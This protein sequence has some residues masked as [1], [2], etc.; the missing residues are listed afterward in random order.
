[1]SRT[2]VSGGRSSRT[3][4]CP[5]ICQAR[6]CTAMVELVASAER[7]LP[8]SSRAQV[9]LL[10][11]SGRLGLEGPKHLQKKIKVMLDVGPWLFMRLSSS[12]MN[13]HTEGV[14]KTCLLKPSTV[15][16]KWMRTHFLH[17]VTTQQ[18][19]HWLFD[20]S[21]CSSQPLEHSKRNVGDPY[22]LRNVLIFP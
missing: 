15:F 11:T 19:L 22:K 18:V 10:V 5:F 13:R 6:I 1:M 2:L 21:S 20:L 7:K 12:H 4:A 14:K 16:W 3:R 9:N 8:L 17:I